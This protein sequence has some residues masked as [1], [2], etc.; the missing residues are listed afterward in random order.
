M[1]SQEILA[2]V[3]FTLSC[4]GPAL[5][6]RFTN[7]HDVGFCA[8]A[9]NA[10]PLSA[11]RPMEVMNL[12]GLEGCDR[13]CRSSIYPLSPYIVHTILMNG[14]SQS[15]SVRREARIGSQPVRASHARVHRKLRNHPKALRVDH[16]KYVP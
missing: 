4:A 10:K 6:I 3:V 9:Y 13:I 5:R 12:V 2:R 11:R 1:G 14:V 8:A 15:P 16:T 7:Q